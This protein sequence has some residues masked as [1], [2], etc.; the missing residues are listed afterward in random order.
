MAHTG[1]W[2]S[3]NLEAEALFPDL[4]SLYDIDEPDDPVLAIE[5]GA[6]HLT[7][8]KDFEGN[9]LSVRPAVPE[10]NSLGPIVWFCKSPLK[11]EGWV[12]AGKDKSDLPEQYIQNQ[13]R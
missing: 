13:L 5:D 8:K 3:D 4:E 10:G 11:P 2:P 1:V 6:L 9:R 7:L 12:V